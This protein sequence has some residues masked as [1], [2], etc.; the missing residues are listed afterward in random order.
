MVT[1]TTV[2]VNLP[3]TGS[4]RTPISPANHMPLAHGTRSMTIRTVMTAIT[5]TVTL[6]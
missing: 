6:R 4:V 5:N 2:G 3:I 1:R